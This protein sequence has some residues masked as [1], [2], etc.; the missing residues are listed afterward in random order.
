VP[1][2]VTDGD[3]EEGKDDTNRVVVKKGSG[4][5]RSM[6]LRLK[7]QAGLCFPKRVGKVED[8]SIQAL[9]VFARRTAEQD[10]SLAEIKKFA[11]ASQSEDED[12]TS[13]ADVGETAASDSKNSKSDTDTDGVV[14]GSYSCL[15]SRAGTPAQFRH[16]DA[17]LYERQ[18][19][20]AISGNGSRPTVTHIVVD[21]LE[22]PEQVIQLWIELVR[23]YPKVFPKFDGSAN[24][25]ADDAIIDEAAASI[26]AMMKSSR[27]IPEWI[28]NYGKVLGR[29]SR[30]VEI[31]GAW[32]PGTVLSVPGGNVHNAP[33]SDD[34]RGILFF[35]SSPAGR[36]TY[37]VDL[38]FSGPTLAASLLLDL[39]GRSNSKTHDE[40]LRR[41]LYVSVLEDPAP[42]DFTAYLNEDVLP[43]NPVRQI[44][45]E[46]HEHKMSLMGGPGAAGAEGSAN[47]GAAPVAEASEAPASP[48]ASSPGLRPRR[49]K[50]RLP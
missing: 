21:D 25:L 34:F 11:V 17:H 22:T 30:T 32:S 37:D 10:P 4:K 9:T 24:V 36:E 12:G 49:K 20:M 39:W 13:P 8:Q 45:V 48:D 27:W 6:I 40:F 42:V 38:Q 26:L 28:A 46:A 43:N 5:Y 19:T 14:F 1:K 16:V 44:M 7:K 33:P 35:T 15:V 23:E 3:N 29:P 50:Q 31:C 18:Y 2:L 47:A 41:V